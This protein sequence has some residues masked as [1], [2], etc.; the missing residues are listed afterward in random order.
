MDE[1][2]KDAR[3]WGK[4]IVK[5]ADNLKPYKGSQQDKNRRGGK[6]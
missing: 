2:S 5:K 3:R 1:G 4:T 6:K